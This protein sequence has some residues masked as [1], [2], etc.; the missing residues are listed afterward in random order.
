M[1][2]Y[3]CKQLFYKKVKKM[4]IIFIQIPLHKSMKDEWESFVK[5]PNGL[6]FTSKQKGFISAEYG[7]AIDINDKLTWN[8]WEK[9]ESREDFERYHAERNESGF[10]AELDKLIERNAPGPVEI[11]DYEVLN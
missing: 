6:E 3:T 2:K 7:Y 4:Q 9:W 11:M 8:C 5:S 10:L 1:N